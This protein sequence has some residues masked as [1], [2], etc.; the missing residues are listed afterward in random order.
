MSVTISVSSVGS[1]AFQCNQWSVRLGGVV[2][3]VVDNWGP[4]M[5]LGVSVGVV[6]RDVGGDVRQSNAGNGELSSV[7]MLW[8]CVC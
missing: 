2:G 4:R 3:L 8:T 5:R 6:A 7:Y 1:S